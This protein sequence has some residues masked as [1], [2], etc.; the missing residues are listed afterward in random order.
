MKTYTIDGYYGASKTPAKI[1]VGEYW[2]G[3]AYYCVDGSCNVN[4]TCDELED[5]INVEEVED[6][7]TF[8]TA[9]PITSETDLRLAIED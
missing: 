1:F 2:P 7:D 5:G 6:I 8:T 3:N 9:N 4:K